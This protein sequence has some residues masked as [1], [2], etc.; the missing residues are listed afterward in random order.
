MKITK[1]ILKQIIK[2]ELLKE[3]VS[4]ENIEK[5]VKGQLLDKM[6]RGR[7][8]TSTLIDQVF[9]YFQESVDL[10]GNV[11]KKYIEDV[12]QDPVFNKYYD[13]ADN[14]HA[15]YEIMEAYI[16]KHIEENPGTS[17][18]GVF[19]ELD[20]DDLADL[21]DRLS[22]EGKITDKG[23]DGAKYY[24]TKKDLKESIKQI[25]KEHLLK[26]FGD[27]PMYSEPELPDDQKKIDKS[28]DDFF[29]NKVG[30]DA[31]IEQIK[32]TKAA[33]TPSV[34]SYMLE[35]FEV[36]LKNLNSE[37]RERLK[38]ALIKYGIRREAL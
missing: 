7:I 24:P 21:I 33:E 36:L 13:E 11:S 28:I 26:E 6:S 37:D 30:I 2:E 14:Y 4:E 18:E 29:E 22:K 20:G 15:T 8:D 34:R 19:P 9:A 3:Q 10:Y 27:G 5:E 38:A 25:V 1:T 32:A 35:T 12:L 17:L 31:V 23:T 16:L